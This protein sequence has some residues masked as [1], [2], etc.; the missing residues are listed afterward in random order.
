ML[1]VHAIFHDLKRLFCCSERDSVV[2]GSA[3][4][5]TQT[6][7]GAWTPIVCFSVLLVLVSLFLFFFLQED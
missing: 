6:A 3:S 4:V 7:Y 5:R 2:Q 1:M